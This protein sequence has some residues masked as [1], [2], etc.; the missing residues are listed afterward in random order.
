MII[1]IK[2][3]YYSDSHIQILSDLKLP[4]ELNFFD[5]VVSSV[6]DKTKEM[7][8]LRLG[9]RY[10]DLQISEEDHLFQLD[11]SQQNEALYRM[12]T[13]ERMKKYYSD[14]REEAKEDARKDAIVAERVIDPDE[15]MMR[16]YFGRTY[17][18]KDLPSIST[19]KA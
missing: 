2:Y 14:E 3:A 4:F 6:S 7:L 5:L 19:S 10:D 18:V 12:Q 13:W 8:W 15:D 16:A 11:E 17:H 1:S 9:F